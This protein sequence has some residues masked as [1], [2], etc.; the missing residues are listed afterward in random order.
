MK[1][2]ATAEP[3][4]IVAAD[5]QQWAVQRLFK[6]VNPP[7][8]KRDDPPEWKTFNYFW[9]RDSMVQYLRQQKAMDTTLEIDGL[10]SEALEMPAEFSDALYRNE[11]GA[12]EGDGHDAP[13]AAPQDRQ[14]GERARSR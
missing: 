8:S 1:V 9:N 12:P 11:G 10:V 3:L 13:A 2:L 14:E 4:R 7:P 6:Y 5:H